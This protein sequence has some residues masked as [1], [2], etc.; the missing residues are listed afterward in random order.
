MTEP[1]PLLPDA[2]H[3]TRSP[4]QDPVRAAA[5]EPARQ[6]TA[7]RLSQKLGRP[8]RAVGSRAAPAEPSSGRV[9]AGSDHRGGPARTLCLPTMIL[10]SPASSGTP[11]PN[12]HALTQSNT[13]Y[14]CRRVPRHHRRH[15]P[16][17]PP[18][19]T[20]PRT[21]CY[22]LRRPATGEQG[23]ERRSAAICATADWALVTECHPGYWSGLAPPCR[24]GARHGP[25]WLALAG[26]AVRSVRWRCRGWRSVLCTVQCAATARRAAWRL[27]GMP[28]GTRI[29]SL[30]LPTRAGRSVAVA[31]LAV[32]CSPSRFSP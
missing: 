32:T 24:I 23:L 18:W 14:R 25:D 12:A 20:R 15:V 16:R 11:A 27:G 8:A 2:R 5:T 3:M 17:F 19:P 13:L 9:L 22:A 1:G 21:P 30:T 7:S 29:V 4:A 31:K 28:P 10:P 6:A 26:L